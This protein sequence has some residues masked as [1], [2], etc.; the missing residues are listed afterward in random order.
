MGPVNDLG[1]TLADPQVVHRNMVATVGG[2][3]V[4]PGPAVKFSGREPRTLA[5]APGLGEHTAEVLAM[6]G[7]KETELDDLRTAGVV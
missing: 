7:V 1:E 5:R 4:G 2:R 3:P 6:V